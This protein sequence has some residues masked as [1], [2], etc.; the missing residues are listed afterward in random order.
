MF[1]NG[2]RSTDLKALAF[3]LWKV[4]V[5]VWTYSRPL[6]KKLWNNQWIGT[7]IQYQYVNALNIFTSNLAKQED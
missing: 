2:N 7:V 5:Y 4:A 1:M 3:S 6:E